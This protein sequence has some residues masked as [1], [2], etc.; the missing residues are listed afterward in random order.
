[1]LSCA[2]KKGLW[3]KALWYEGLE[4]KNLL[5]SLKKGFVVVINWADTKTLSAV[6]RWCEGPSCCQAWE[7]CVPLRSVLQRGNAEL[8]C[9]CGDLGNTIS[10]IL[11]TPE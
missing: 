10:G 8:L 5:S 6:L 4:R 1:M 3:Q 11:L 2:K 9:K 7:L